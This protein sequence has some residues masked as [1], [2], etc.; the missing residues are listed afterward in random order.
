MANKAYKTKRVFLNTLATCIQMIVAQII[1]LFI[2]KRVLEVYGSDLNGVNAILSNAMEWILILE[3]G[4]TLASN[5]ALFKP[6]VSGDYEKCNRI[7]S[8]TRKQFRK[9]GLLVFAVG[10]GIAAIYPFCIKSDIPKYDICIMFAMMTLS[11]SYHT[12][13][14]ML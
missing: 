9:I 12:H 13:A 14:N 10:I 2:S 7:L 4:L 3:G 6:Y 1:S 8:A 5:V 11:T